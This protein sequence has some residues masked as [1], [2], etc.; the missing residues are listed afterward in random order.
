MAFVCPI[1][2][3]MLALESS[4]GS[5]HCKNCV[6]GKPLHGHNLCIACGNGEKCLKCGEGPKNGKDYYSAFNHIVDV[7]NQHFLRT[8]KLPADQVKSKYSVSP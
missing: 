1:C 7:A 3:V 5:R 4:P 6:M 8:Q 2:A